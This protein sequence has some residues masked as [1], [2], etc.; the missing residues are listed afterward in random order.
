MYIYVVNRAAMLSAIV[1]MVIPHAQAQS[2]TC[3]SL[4]QPSQFAT[5]GKA[6]SITSADL[7]GDGRPDM[8]MTVPGTINS[9]SVLRN[10]SAGASNLAFTTP[11]NFSTGMNPQF[12]TTADFNNDGKPDVAVITTPASPA[13][14]LMSIFINTSSGPGNISFANRVDIPLPANNAPIATGDF[15][16]DGRVDVATSDFNSVIILLNNTPAHALSPAFSP[17]VTVATPPVTQPFVLA[18]GDLNGDGRPDIVFVGHGVNILQNVTRAPGAPT[19]TPPIQYLSSVDGT[20][21][22]VLADFN[23]DGLTDIGVAIADLKITT[24]V[25]VMINQTT[26]SGNIQFTP[27]GANAFPT[28]PQF[29]NSDPFFSSTFLMA[30]DFD[31]DGKQDLLV[32]ALNAPNFEIFFNNTTGSSVTFATVVNFPTDATTALAVGNFVGIRPEIV[33]GNTSLNKFGQNTVGTF[34]ND[35]VPG[36]LLQLTSSA[37]PGLAGQS[38]ALTVTGTTTP[39]CGAASGTVQI[40]DGSTPLSSAIQLVSTGPTTS[41]GSQQYQLSPGIHFLKAVYTPSSGPYLGTTSGVLAQ[42]I[43]A[44]SCAVNLGAQVAI[45]QSGM[46]YDRTA[47]QFVQSVTL[48]NSGAAALSGPISLV[49]NNLSANAQLASPSGFTSCGAQTPAPFE[50]AGICTGGSM[51]P[52][53]SVSMTLRFNDPSMQS[54]GYSATVVGGPLPR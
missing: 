54:I 9:L 28:I 34:V 50:D 36:P 46:R 18:A 6:S 42:V 51:A 33:T 37:N 22:I 5:A 43:N 52:G 29:T 2:Q 21:P 45:S 27:P 53:S 41:A 47:G 49:L 35:G 3:F 10:I 25:T 17:G 32:G 11:L 14:S 20:S 30:A 19:F 48:T 38:L 12:V 44:S 8:I 26:G 4:S 31:G 23:G 39:V 7:D 16:G 13:V 15:D 24:F 1:S 40:L